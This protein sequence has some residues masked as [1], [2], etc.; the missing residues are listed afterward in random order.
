MSQRRFLHIL[1]GNLLCILERYTVVV[2][3]NE[4]LNKFF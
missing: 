1:L 2:F 4:F 3:L